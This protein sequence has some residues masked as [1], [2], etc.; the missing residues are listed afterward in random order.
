MASI[1]NEKSKTSEE[2]L[3]STT[4]SVGNRPNI[5]LILADDLGY[6]D[7]SC[8][9]AEKINTPNID[10]VASE[11]MR[12]TQGYAGY[13]ICSPSR[14]CLLSGRYAWRSDRHPSTRVMAPA[15]PLVFEADRITLGKLLLNEGYTTACIG[16]WHLGFGEG[17]QEERYD[18]N[19]R[20]I[21]NGPLAAGFDYFF[22]TAAN[23]ENYPRIFIENDKFVG[24]EPE[25]VV[26]MDGIQVIPWST[27]AEYDC[28]E[29]N[30]VLVGKACDFI[31]ESVMT[32]E[33]PFF[34]YYAS[35]IPHSPITPNPKF[36]GS[37]ACGP[38]GDFIQ[39]LDYHV[40]IILDT[41]N[42]TGVADNTIVI[43]TS[44]NGAVVPEDNTG[45]SK[46]IWDAMQAGHHP[47]GDLRG[48]KH[49]VYEGG[50]R[51]PFNVKWPKVTSASTESDALISLVDI[52]ATLADGLNI[53]MPI[54]T[55]EDSVSFLNVLQHGDHAQDSRFNV[56]NQSALGVRSIRD[57]N[58]KYIRPWIVP[59]DVDLDKLREHSPKYLLRETNNPEN[60]EQ[61]YDLHNDPLETI[62]VLNENKYQK[63]VE[64]LKKEL[65]R[66][67]EK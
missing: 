21:E 24:R 4:D 3:F 17:D 38:Y 22:G 15:Q 34:L 58:G 63:K 6:G 27:E 57:E 36:V 40:G 65:H 47:C 39:E 50:T 62:N 13:A 12:F 18:W 66:A 29:A 30:A 8:Y 55:A 16:K 56:I 20:T 11:G 48:R 59:E 33:R 26:R 53:N 67:E 61:Y 10:R 14:Y 49:S 35:T 2:V 46:P 51:I 41:L 25:D 5:V 45:W 19:K 42:R 1:S 60:Y 52:M 32:E 28:E 54:N 43:F 44:D 37:S 9:G 31:E 23:L 7:V 64:H